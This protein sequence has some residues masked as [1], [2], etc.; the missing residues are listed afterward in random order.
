MTRHEPPLPDSSVL[1]RARAVI[2]L[3]AFLLVC[4]RADA[5]SLMVA[6]AA[7]VSGPVTLTSADG[8]PPF[9][10]TRGY[11]LS[12]GDR[13]DTRGGGR[14]VIDLSDG[15]MVVVQPESIIEIKDFRAASSLRE[16]FDITLGQVRVRINH[17]VG[18][19]K[20]LSHE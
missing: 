3:S 18:R 7:S 19:R 20:P 1:V 4:G 10:L 12:P 5:Q 6:R 17:F 14:V 9:A 8:T 13:I 15:S 2:V 11:G 16:L